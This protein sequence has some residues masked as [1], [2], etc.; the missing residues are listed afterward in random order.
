MEDL[1]INTGKKVKAEYSRP[2]TTHHQV[3]VV[4]GGSAGISVAAQLNNRLKNSDIAI[5]EPSSDHFYQPLWTLA[6]VGVVDKEVTH[7]PMADVIPSGTVW[8]RDAV[9]V[10]DPENQ[11]VMTNKGDHYS[12]D[13]LV[14]APGIQVNWNAVPGL[15][16]GLGK[17]GICS[18]Y[19][20]RYVDYV[21]ECVVNLKE[22]TALFTQP[23]G[24][25][26][27]GGAPQKIMY[28]SSDT[29]R[30][31]GVLK[32]IDVN[33]TSGGSMIFGVP[34]I[35]EALKK[36]IERYSISTHFSHNLKEIKADEKV[37]VYDI[38]KDEKVVDEKEIKFDMLHVT[39]PMSAPDF[40]KKSPLANAEGWV[41]VHKHTLQHNKYSNVFGLGDAG[42]TPNAKTGAA[43][44][45]QSKVVSSNILSLIN[46][47]ELDKSQYY[48]GYG[49]CPLLTG[50]G[51]LIL[52]EFD[53]DNNMTPSFPIN[54]AKERR[55]MYYMKR[56]L[57]PL[58]Y[59]QGML[60]GRA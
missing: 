6:G 15:A 49:S 38:Y 30:R 11:L 12:Y 10:F 43:V 44:R 40:V 58:M 8:I 55:S 52:A 34:E 36:P 29:W 19:S 45:K 7:K 31:S 48:K 54:Q 50:Y 28:M 46:K 57:L 3:I 59:W 41:D 35:A 18:V 14:V 5:I 21:N 17:N 33:F 27:C 4:G 23:M 47:G 9:A 16:E 25:F 56:D 2:Y 26:K 37:A 20:Y 32:N 42:S 22:G 60:K 24:P 13:Y 51:K 1:K 39:P 53:Y